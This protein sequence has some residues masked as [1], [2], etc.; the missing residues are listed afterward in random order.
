MRSLRRLCQITVAGMFLLLV[1]GSLVTNTG[2]ADGCGASWPFCDGDWSTVS[3]WIEANH[4][5]VTGALG[6]LIAAT[7]WL[8]WRRH[9]RDS[10]IR[11]LVGASIFFLLLQSALGAIAVVWGSSPAVM[12]SHFGVSLASFGSVFLL[13]LRV[14][15]LQEDATAPAPA[16]NGGEPA[17]RRLVAAAL[18]LTLIVVYGGAYVRHTGTG[19]ACLGW[20]LCNGEWI[21]EL[22]GDVGINFAHRLMAAALTLFTLH[23]PRR[24]RALRAS[25]PELHAGALWAAV[26]IVLQT[27]SGALV[28]LTGGSIA[29]NMI[30]SAII[31]LYV[32]A[33]LY[34]HFQAAA[35][36]L[37]QEA[38]LEPDPDRSLAQRPVG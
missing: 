5:L 33:L 20:P 11:W 18:V 21:P 8:A 35:W 23:L 37:P 30:H 10:A 6:I 15:Q 29:S 17:F 7:S 2:S 25:R 1:T 14:V 3:T 38:G 34:L 26:L 24:A 13:A 32:G 16:R 4:R 28:A 12:A 27:L 31:T 36:P 9:G 19:T 22:S